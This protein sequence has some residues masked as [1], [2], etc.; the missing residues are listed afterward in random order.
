MKCAW[1]GDSRAI[2]VRYSDTGGKTE[3]TALTRDHKAR[4]ARV[5]FTLRAAGGANTHA[6]IVPSC[7]NAVR[8]RLAAHIGIMSCG[9][10]CEPRRS[11]AR[12]HGALGGAP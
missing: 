9:S 11:A 6:H 10:A 12:V 1:V 4:D 3:V 8:S 2:L 7:P 5:R